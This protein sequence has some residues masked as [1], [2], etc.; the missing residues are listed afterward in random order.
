MA[1]FDGEGVRRMDEHFLFTLLYLL[2][3]TYLDDEKVSSSEKIRMA[4][5]LNNLVDCPDCQSTDP[6]IMAI[7]SALK[8]IYSIAPHSRP[9]LKSC[10]RSELEGVVVQSCGHH[11]REKY[12][13]IAERK[14]GTM[15]QAMRSI[16]G[17]EITE[18][19][20]ALGACVQL[21]DDMCDV[22]SDRDAGIYTIATYDLEHEGN[23]DRLLFYTIHRIDELHRPYVPFK[24]LFMIL[25][26]YLVT[27]HPFFTDETT[28]LLTPLSIIDHREGI[29]LYQL[30]GRW[31]GSISSAEGENS[32][33]LQSK[34]ES[35]DR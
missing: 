9:W 4:L 2:T 10:L 29:D 31:I 12:L 15:T 16:I 21:F 22:A 14:G 19:D 26:V 6:T 23:L 5:E 32:V 8:G 28:K 7:S 18:E 24:P 33:F 25:L 20:Y 27:R 3:D 17:G 1:I 11:P 34:T 13:E 30:A 35:R